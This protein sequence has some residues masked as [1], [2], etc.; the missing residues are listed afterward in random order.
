[1][2]TVNPR[3]ALLDEMKR[4]I[5]EERSVSEYPYVAFRRPLG[6]RRAKRCDALLVRQH[7]AAQLRVAE[8]VLADTAIE[9][10]LPGECRDFRTLITHHRLG[11]AIASIAVVNSSTSSSVL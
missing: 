2:V 6:K 7:H 5:P 3:D 9:K 8:N 4:R 1:M 11:A 10:R